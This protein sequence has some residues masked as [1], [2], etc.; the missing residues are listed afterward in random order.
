MSGRTERTLSHQLMCQAAGTFSR[1]GGAGDP[2][3]SDRS[4][5]DMSPEGG[6]FFPKL[7]Y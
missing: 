6:D 5:L 2:V 7:A 4:L 3:D 1:P